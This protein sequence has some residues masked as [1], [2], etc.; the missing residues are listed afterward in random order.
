MI[1]RPAT[2]TDHEAIRACIDAAFGQPTEGTLVGALRKARDARI[3]LVA[4]EADEVIGHVL[5][6]RLVSP[7]KCLGLAPLSVLP[8]HQKRGVGA[9]LTERA[10]GEARAAGWDAIFLLG[11][12][13]YYSRFGFSVG[14]AAKFGTVYPKEFMMALELRAGRLDALE[15]DISYAP[16]FAEIV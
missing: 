6:S 1:V 16:A 12:P 15:G 4:D 2:P 14:A 7:R 9:A 3:E 10:I 11:E 5:L 13:H 8:A